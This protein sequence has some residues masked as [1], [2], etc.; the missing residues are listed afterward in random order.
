MSIISYKICDNCGEKILSSDPTRY[1]N[2]K[3][4]T[5]LH[6]TEGLTLLQYRVDLC[7][8]C[9][10]KPIVFLELFSTA[11]YEDIKLMEKL[12]H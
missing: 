10:K 6:A 4:F 5:F 2:S 7:G 9:V 1:V 12:R 11:T 3:S 8:I